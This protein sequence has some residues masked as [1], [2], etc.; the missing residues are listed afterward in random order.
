MG[1]KGVKGDT[2]QPGQ[3]GDVGDRGQRGMIGI[4]LYN[5]INVISGNCM[6]VPL[7][8]DHGYPGPPGLSG[9]KGNAITH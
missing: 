3:R 2:G 5:Y 8:G 7:L 9:Q 1:I 4:Q 6:Y